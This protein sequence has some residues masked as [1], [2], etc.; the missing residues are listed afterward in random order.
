MGILTVTAVTMQLWQGHRGPGTP[1]CCRVAR[2]AAVHA[3]SLF[4]PL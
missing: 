1:V 4:C 3:A 2:P